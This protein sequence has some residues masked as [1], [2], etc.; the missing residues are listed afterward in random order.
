[1]DVTNFIEN[2][3]RELSEEI[4]PEYVELYAY[5]TND[6]L[7]EIL[8]TLHA[9]LVNN[10]KIMNERLPTNEYEQHFW[11]EPSRN[12]IKYIEMSKRL[13]RGL[14]HTTF[15]LEIDEYYEK[16]ITACSQFLC[17]SGG[18]SIPK[19]MEKITL[20]YTLPIFK[21]TGVGKTG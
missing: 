8:S 3:Y 16:L 5:T 11:A 18:S 20:Y 15:S 2:I 13:Q 19:N 10:F 6:K 12:L 17:K 21:P 4:T 1:M 7:R 9:G 14:K